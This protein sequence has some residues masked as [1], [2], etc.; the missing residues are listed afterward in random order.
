MV[1]ITVPVSLAISRA[2]D[3][4]LTFQALHAGR[5]PTVRRRVRE[6]RMRLPGSSVSLAVIVG[7]IVVVLVIPVITETE[8]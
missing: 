1:A 4:R 5:A 3:V 7:V 2:V 8:S 6:L